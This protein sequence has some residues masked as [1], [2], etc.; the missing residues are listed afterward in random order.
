MHIIIL[1]YTIILLWYIGRI[2]RTR[3]RLYY[4]IT[5][6]KHYNGCIPITIELCFIIL[7]FVFLMFSVIFNNGGRDEDGR[8]IFSLKKKIIKKKNKIKN[9]SSRVPSGERWR[10]GIAWRLDRRR[11]QQKQQIR[12][13]IIC[14]LYFFTFISVYDNIEIGMNCAWLLVNDIPRARRTQKITPT[15]RYIYIIRIFW[16]VCVCTRARVK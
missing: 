3:S 13:Y 14:V 16:C 1:L 9:H 2:K 5:R 12:I 15:G 7:F 6:Y 4:Y 8:I 11:P 10:T